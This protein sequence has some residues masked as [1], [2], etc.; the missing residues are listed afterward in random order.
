MVF[1]DAVM[2]DGDAFA[3][4]RVGVGVGGRAVCGPACVADADGARQ[5]SAG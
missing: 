3:D 1:D 2:D 4:M 5:V